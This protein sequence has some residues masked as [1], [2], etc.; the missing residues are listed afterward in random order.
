MTSR[1]LLLAVLAGFVF[2]TSLS[3]H[4]ARVARE[5]GEPKDDVHRWEGEGGAMPVGPQ[6]VASDPEVE[7]LH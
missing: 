7:P 4:R 6:R 2:G 1:F 3:A 5:H